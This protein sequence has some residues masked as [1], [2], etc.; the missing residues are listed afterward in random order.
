VQ[1]LK[2]KDEFRAFFSVHSFIGMVG[3]FRRDATRWVR[4][5]MTT[6]FALLY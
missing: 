3:S 6:R 4:K 5:E 1:V 2:A